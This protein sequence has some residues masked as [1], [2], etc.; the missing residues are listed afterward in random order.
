MFAVIGRWKLDPSQA[1]VQREVLTQRIVPG[2]RQANGFVAGYW[3]EPTEAGH[4]HT[5]IVF[6]E[7]AAAEAFADSVRR[8]RHDRESRGVEGDELTVVEL[9][10]HA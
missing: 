9:M 2:V 1:Q 6:D 7:L 3:S 5:F 4:A 8:N 10:A